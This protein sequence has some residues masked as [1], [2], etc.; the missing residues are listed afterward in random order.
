VRVEFAELG[1]VQAQ[2]GVTIFDFG[3]VSVGF[4]MP[5]SA[6]PAA[7]LRWAGTLADSTPLIQQARGTVTPLHDQLMPAIQHPRCQPQLSQEHL[8][9][10]FGPD[11]LPQTGDDACLAGMVHLECGPLSAEEIT[12][13]LRY[14][15]SYSPDDLFVP[16]WAAAVLV[17]RDCEDT[18]HA[19]DFA[20]LQLLE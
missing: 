10:Q 4:H 13:A 20:N 6:S 12:E 9:F 16:D 18:L 1:T 7:L 17:D 2:A 14:R 3:A 5:F 15:L 8:V 11:M 19:I